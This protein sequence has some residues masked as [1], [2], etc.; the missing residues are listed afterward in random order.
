MS[1]ERSIKRLKTCLEG[2]AVDVASVSDVVRVDE[3]DVR[4]VLE[5]L[6]VA[7]TYHRLLRDDLERFAEYVRADALRP[8]EQTRKRVEKKLE[9][10]LSGQNENE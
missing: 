4:N 8:T 9:F 6:A 10:L 2:R 7:P 1:L 3:N 5:A